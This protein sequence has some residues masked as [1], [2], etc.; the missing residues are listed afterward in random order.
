M[1]FLYYHSY[2]KLYTVSK[3]SF[4]AVYI[5]IRKFIVSQQNIYKMSIEFIYK[6]SIKFIYNHHSRKISTF[7]PLQFSGQFYSDRMTGKIWRL[8]GNVYHRMAIGGP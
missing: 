4:M 2:N 5:H 8:I 3:M 7:H 1:L 6:M